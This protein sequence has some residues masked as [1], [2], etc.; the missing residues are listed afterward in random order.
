MDW[1]IQ[2]DSSKFDDPLTVHP[3]KKLVATICDKIL[4]EAIFFELVFLSKSILGKDYLTIQRTKDFY[5]YFATLEKNY[6]GDVA[7]LLEN[8]FAKL[9]LHADLG[10]YNFYLYD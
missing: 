3:W 9:N 4:D 2:S 7:E 5:M 6:E 10:I 8:L 1:N